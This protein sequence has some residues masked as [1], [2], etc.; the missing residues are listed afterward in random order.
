MDVILMIHPNS[1]L[2]KKST[3]QE[4][5]EIFGNYDHNVWAL[6]QKNNESCIYSDNRDWGIFSVK[7]E[8]YT[9]ILSPYDQLFP[10]QVLTHSEF[11]LYFYNRFINICKNQRLIH[12]RELLASS[13]GFDIIFEYNELIE[14]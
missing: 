12:H 7:I 8:Q 4:I 10:S 1:A 2:Y 3:M 5:T 9:V 11:L 14:N 13:G 6:S